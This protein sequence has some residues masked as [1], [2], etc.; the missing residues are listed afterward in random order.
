MRPYREYAPTQFDTKGLHGDRL[1]RSG[2]LV[3]PCGRNRDSDC[4]QESNFHSLLKAIGGESVDVEVHRFG[5]W[6]CG[7]FEI[8][9]IRPGSE[10]E[11]KAQAVSDALEDYPVVDE[12]DWATR[13]D[14]AKHQYWAG[15]ALRWRV[16]ECRR[17]GASIF[18]A[19]RTDD[20]PERVYES[21]EV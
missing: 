15:L 18:A 7:W 8:V 10:A 20:I 2:W 3:G 5:H 16:D 12:D 17:H 21:I 1:D 4:L 14:E 19:R 11:S 13:E 6:A 9:L